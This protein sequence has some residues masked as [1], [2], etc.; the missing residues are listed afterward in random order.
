MFVSEKTV[1]FNRLGFSLCALSM[2]EAAGEAKSWKCLRLTRPRRVRAAK[3]AAPAPL[4]RGGQSHTR[5]RI[6]LGLGDLSG[7]LGEQFAR[8]IHEGCRGYAGVRNAVP[9]GSQRYATSREPLP[10]DKTPIV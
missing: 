8:G 7:L 10:T 2:G 6:G 4:G 5:A 9:T 1:F 3:E